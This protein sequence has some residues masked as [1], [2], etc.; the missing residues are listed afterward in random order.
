MLR[1]LRKRGY[2]AIDGDNELAYRGDPETGKRIPEADEDL[3]FDYGVWIWNID[4]VNEIVTDKH[5]EI[6]FFCG[7]SRNFHKFISSFDKV[8]VLDVSPEIL[9][10]RLESRELDDMGGTREQ[11]DFILKM[12][13]SKKAILPEGIAIDTER[14]LSEVVDTILEHV[15]V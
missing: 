11:R 10:K 14:P 6:T 3:D 12:H 2:K 5:D 1:E 7:G 8:F 15:G 9:V 13:R 4:K